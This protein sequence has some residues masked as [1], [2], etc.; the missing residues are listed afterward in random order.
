MV[1]PALHLAPAI[2]R[3]RALVSFAAL[4]LCAV[5]PASAQ[6]VFTVTGTANSSAE[7][8]TMGNSYTFVF[9]SAASF[10]NADYSGFDSGGNLHR[11]ELDTD[12]QM[13]TAIGGTGRVGTYVRPTSTPDDPYSYLFNN[14]NNLELRVGKDSGPAIGLTTLNGT[15]IGVLNASITGGNM[16]TFALPGVYVEPFNASTGYWASYL[17]TYSGFSG[18]GNQITL[19]NSTYS[20]ELVTFTTTALTISAAA[21]PEPSTYAALAGLAALGLV[22]FRR[23][24]ANAA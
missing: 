22:A 15:E 2:S 1:S 9:T 3:M 21:V 13:W 17:G 4:L 24:H 10:A 14:A 19:Y 16:P 23:R 5:V 20:S 7:G 6:I 12:P 18:G 8:Y 11:E